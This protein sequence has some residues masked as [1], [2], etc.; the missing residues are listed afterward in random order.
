MGNF[1]AGDLAR[2]THIRDLRDAD[3]VYF[4]PSNRYHR[5]ASFIR[6]E[7]GHAR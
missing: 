6:E 4:D 2:L 3:Q 1:P 5:S 7:T